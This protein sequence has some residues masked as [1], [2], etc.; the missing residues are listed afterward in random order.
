MAVAQVIETRAYFHEQDTK[1]PE[2]PQP[3]KRRRLQTPTLDSDSLQPPAWQEH[4]CTP[5]PDVAEQDPSPS[6]TQAP[7]PPPR[8]PVVSKVV[9]EALSAPWIGSADFHYGDDDNFEDPNDEPAQPVPGPAELSSS[10]TDSDT[11]MDDDVGSNESDM[12]E[13]SDIFE[14]NADLNAAEHSERPLPCHVDPQN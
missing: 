5:P 9:R 11:D 3:R 1:S 10:E 13:V 12:G 4:G 14:T 2:P 6:P 7:T 8:S